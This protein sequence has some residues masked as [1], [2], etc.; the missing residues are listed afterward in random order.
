MDLEQLKYPIGRY[1]APESITDAM[2]SQWISEIEQLPASLSEVVKGLTD[3]QLATPY[4]DGGWTVRQTVHHIADSHI[5]A[6]CR[7]KLALT[8]D[9]PTIK[10]YIESRWAELE[11]G[12]NALVESSLMLVEA[13]HKRWL[14]LL[15]ALQPAD[16]KRTYIH[17]EYGKEFLLQYLAGLYAWHGKHHVAQIRSLRERMKW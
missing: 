8:E 1:K 3:S 6:Y 9:R 12:R 7:F 5:N 14:I 10:P 17:P 4:R 2:I 16:F 15:R 11:D 13:V